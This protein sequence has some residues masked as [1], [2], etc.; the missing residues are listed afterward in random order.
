ML[1][2]SLLGDTKCS[3]ERTPA[4]ELQ[5]SEGHFSSSDLA[6]ALNLGQ[7]TQISEYSEEN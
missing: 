1:E 5:S 2:A 6:F 7:G 3:Q 4:R